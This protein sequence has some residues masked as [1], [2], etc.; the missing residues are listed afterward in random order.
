MSPGAHEHFFR[1]VIKCV[2]PEIIPDE[3]SQAQGIAF[4]LLLYL[5]CATS[6]IAHQQ[7]E[8]SV[9][10]VYM[11]SLFIAHFLRGILLCTAAYSSH[12]ISHTSQCKGS[13]HSLDQSLLLF[14]A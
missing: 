5:S 11:L 9:C 1:I 14:I 12:L 2:T 7:V 13:A 10:V 4:S 8:L 3:Y 6:S